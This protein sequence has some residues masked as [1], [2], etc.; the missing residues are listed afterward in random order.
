MVLVCG[1]LHALAHIVRYIVD[2]DADL[3]YTETVNRSGVVATILM[4]PSVVPMALAYC[5]RRVSNV[6][7]EILEAGNIYIK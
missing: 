5:R 6:R 4:V 2:N 3:L 7:G 1:V